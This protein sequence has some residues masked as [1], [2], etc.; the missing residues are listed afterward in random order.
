MTPEEI[1]NF[2]DWGQPLPTRDA[3]VTEDE[4]QSELGKKVQPT[5]WRM[6]GNKLMA[7]VPGGV[8]VQYL[9][10]DYILKGTDETGLPILVKIEH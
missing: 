3:H 8:M 7:D 1:K 6:Q 10:T 2:Q 9:P 4:V 5:N